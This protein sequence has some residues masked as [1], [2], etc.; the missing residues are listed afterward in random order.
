MM[1]GY[2]L[3]D[4]RTQRQYWLSKLGSDH[5]H[6]HGGVRD[7]SRLP[8]WS[9]SPCCLRDL[10]V[11]FTTWWAT[12]M[13]DWDLIMKR[14]PIHY[15]SMQVLLRS[16]PVSEEVWDQGA[17]TNSLPGQL[18]G[19]SEDGKSVGYF[20]MS[21]VRS[22]FVPKFDFRLICCKPQNVMNHDRLLCEKYGPV[23]G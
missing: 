16:L 8:R 22:K 7:L 15:Q 18:Q 17:A 1:R 23:C 19:Q 9:S 11:S 3:S 12:P 2:C 20:N 5:H 14:R 13:G 21:F 6:H 10:Q 4:W